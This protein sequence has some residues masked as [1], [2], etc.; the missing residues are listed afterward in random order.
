MD[1][2]QARRSAGLSK[3]E[4][5][6]LTGVPRLTIWRYEEK[7]VSRLDYETMTKLTNLYASRT[8]SVS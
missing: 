8:Q 4:V 5:E 3:A 1:L 2:K 6:R 7:K